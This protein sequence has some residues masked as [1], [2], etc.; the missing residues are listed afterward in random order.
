MRRCRKLYSKEE[1]RRNAVDSRFTWTRAAGSIW[2][3]APPP[4]ARASRPP[5]EHRDR[6]RPQTLLYI[7]PSVHHLS[8]PPCVRCECRDAELILPC[9]YPLTRS[10]LLIFRRILPS[11]MKGLHKRASLL[12]ITSEEKERE[13]DGSREREV[14]AAGGRRW[15]KKKKGAPKEEREGGA[16]HPPPQPRNGRRGQLPSRFNGSPRY[17]I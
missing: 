3:A 2:S 15:K 7:F 12:A 1:R 4:P 11:P 17:I 16:P 14:G 10:T 6:P 5:F 13:R 8:D 9:C